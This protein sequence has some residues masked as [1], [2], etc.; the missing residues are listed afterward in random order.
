M[1]TLKLR[2]LYNVSRRV[3]LDPDCLA[4]N[5]SSSAYHEFW[6]VI[7]LQQPKPL[8]KQKQKLVVKT[9]VYYYSCIYGLDGW[10]WSSGLDL[11]YFIWNCSY[12]CN[13]LAGWW[14]GCCSRVASHICGGLLALLWGGG[15]LRHMSLI[16]H[17]WSLGLF[18]HGGGRILREVVETCKISWGLHMELARHFWLYLAKFIGQGKSG[19]Q[20]K[21]KMWGNQ[22]LSSYRRSQGHIAGGMDTR[23]AGEF[24]PFYNHSAIQ[25]DLAQSLHLSKP[26]S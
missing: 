3:S 25:R 11:A 16:I 6:L 4:L 7:A 22:L 17:Q 15:W 8:P 14:W 20:S 19:G 5:P 12:I 24:G 26:V 13:H 21:F 1:S 10:F 9:N 23:R 18:I 2:K